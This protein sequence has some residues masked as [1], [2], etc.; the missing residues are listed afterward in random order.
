[1]YFEI[2]QGASGAEEA[3]YCKSGTTDVVGEEKV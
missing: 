1:L 3:I 2:V